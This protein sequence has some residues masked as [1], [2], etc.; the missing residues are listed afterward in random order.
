MTQYA[1]PN[2][3]TATGMWARYPATGSFYSKIDETPVGTDEGEW[4]VIDN[5]HINVEEDDGGSLSGDVSLGTATFALSTITDPVSDADHV[6]KYRAKYIGPSAPTFDVKL[7]QTS[8]S[9]SNL[10]VS[11]RH[12]GGTA[13]TSSFVDYEIALSTSEADSINDYSDLILT[14]IVSGTGGEEFKGADVSQ[15]FFETGDAGGGGGGSVATTG[16]GPDSFS[17]GGAGFGS[18]F[19]LE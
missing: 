13:L 4:A 19:S 2:A 12:T 6:V 7:Y 5:D 9:L 17:I 1:V 15:L 8:I 18:N 11:K 16:G 14:I 10:I 3:D